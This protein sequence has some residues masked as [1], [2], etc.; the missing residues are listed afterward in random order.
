MEVVLS[1]KEFCVYD[2]I[3]RHQKLDTTCNDLSIRLWSNDPVS[4]DCS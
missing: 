3:P 4:S 1:D 2:M